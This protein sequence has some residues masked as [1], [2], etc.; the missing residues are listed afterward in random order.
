M[1]A[2]TVDRAA[3]GR[4]VVGVDGSP[5]GT[6][7]VRWALT[8]AVATGSDLDAVACWEWP[9]TA[10]GFAPVADLDLSGPT[11][12][13]ADASVAEALADTPGADGVT[14]RT[15]V[16]EGY[17]PRILMGIA[18]DA[19]LL[20]VGSRGHGELRGLVL[21]SVGLHCA[22]HARCPVVVVR[23]GAADAAQV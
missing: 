21:G 13:T 4:I 8:Q 3:R 10:G 22:S 19:D 5:H 2:P 17:A 20:V 9:A 16:S 6:A 1:T 14:V 12:A 23:G 15:T 11:R 18:A 7:A